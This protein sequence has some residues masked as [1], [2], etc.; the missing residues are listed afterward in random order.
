MNFDS[1]ETFLGNLGSHSPDSLKLTNSKYVLHVFFL[2]TFW[3]VFSVLQI[4]WK[5]SYILQSHWG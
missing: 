4:W 1:N 2:H 5:L 3:G